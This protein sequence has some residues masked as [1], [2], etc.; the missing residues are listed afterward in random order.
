LQSLPG[1]TKTFDWR[2]I[3]VSVYNPSTLAFWTY[4]D[5]ATARLKMA[6]IWLRVPGGGNARGPA[7]FVA[8]IGPGIL[9]TCNSE[10]APVSIAVRVAKASV[11]FT[12]NWKL[13]TY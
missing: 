3:A 7:V 8:R 12:R 4:D 2:R 1:F 9:P 5:P 13:E 11:A 6:Y 10:N